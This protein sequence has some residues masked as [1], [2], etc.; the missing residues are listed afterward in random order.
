MQSIWRQW[1][2][3]EHSNSRAKI[4]VIAN[5]LMRSDNATGGGID[6]IKLNRACVCPSSNATNWKRRSDVRLYDCLNGQRTLEMPVCVEL[7]TV[8]GYAS[9]ET[10][11]V[12]LSRIIYMR[13]NIV[14]ECD[15]PDGSA[16]GNR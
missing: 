1:E 9:C 14:A 6:S 5:G 2:K 16:R 7:M 15:G 10:L 8:A 11:S 3:P 13:A 12:C 4:E